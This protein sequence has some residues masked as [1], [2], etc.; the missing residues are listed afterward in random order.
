MPAF[1]PVGRPL[2]EQVDRSEPEKTIEQQKET[3][4]ALQYADLRLKELVSTDEMYYAIEYFLLGDPKRQIEQLGDIEGLVEKG[5]SSKAESDN[6]KARYNY[7]TAAKIELF[8][9]NKDGL[10]R[11][12][13]FA[14]EVTEPNDKYFKFQRTILDNIDETLRVANNYY[15]SIPVTSE[16]TA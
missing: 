14:Q 10:R 9:G 4:E 7:E 6:V 15:Q 2:E 5:N 16:E 3:E 8:R 11:F 12:L 1:D 13:T